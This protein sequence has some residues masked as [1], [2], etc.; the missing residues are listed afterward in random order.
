MEKLLRTFFLLLLLFPLYDIHASDPDEYLQYLLKRIEKPP[1]EKKPSESM[2]SRNEIIFCSGNSKLARTNN[3]AA[4][5]MERGDYTTAEAI[6]SEALK[7]APLFFPLRYNIGLCHV[8]M[9]NLN[10]GLI[11]LQKALYT[12]PEYSK[13]YLQ[14]GYIYQR[15]GKDSTAIDF[16]RKSLERNSKELTA[17]TL[18]GDIYFNRKQYEIAKRYYQASL[19]IDRKLPNGL[20]GLAKIHYIREKFYRAIILI[21]AIDL[22]RDYDKSLHYYYA[23][24]SF[25]LRDYKTAYEQYSTLLRFRNDKFFLTNSVALIEHKLDLTRRFVER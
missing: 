23:E 21:K 12:F 3:R 19:K 10:M 11:H 13:T 14:I 24:C 8:H 16:F 7:H 1:I 20:L 4:Q 15:F 25:N 17:L 18:I 6:L 2:Y 9:N 5:L 22:T